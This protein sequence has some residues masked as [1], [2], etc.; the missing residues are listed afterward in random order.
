[1]EDPLKKQTNKG[2][3]WSYGGSFIFLPLLFFSPSQALFLPSHFSLV[4]SLTL[5][6][7]LCHA[8]TNFD[9]ITAH[10]IDSVTAGRDQSGLLSLIWVNMYKIAHKYIIFYSMVLASFNVLLASDHR[11]NP[12]SSPE[13]AISSALITFHCWSLYN[14]YILYFTP[15][16][17]V[18]FGHIALYSQLYLTTSQEAAVET[19]QPVQ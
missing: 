4:H 5:S 2:G 19:T 11:Q 13:P 17:S 10:N 8:I 18:V 7:S 16:C 6:L 9:I 14:C 12:V 15:I 3:A 1:M